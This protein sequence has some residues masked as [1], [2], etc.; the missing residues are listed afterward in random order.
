MFS[1][2]SNWSFETLQQSLQKVKKVFKERHDAVASCQ[3]FLC[4][5]NKVSHCLV[6][7]LIP[8]HVGRG[9]VGCCRNVREAFQVSGFS[10]GTTSFFEAEG[11]D[12]TKLCQKVLQQVG[13]KS[14]FKAEQVQQHIQG[15]CYNQGYNQ[16]RLQ[17]IRYQ[18]RY[19]IATMQGLGSL[20]CTMAK[21]E[22]D[23]TSIYLP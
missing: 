4:Q 16:K 17:L 9:S 22:R 6:S 23:T 20:E 14:Y 8:R 5:Y 7:L 21:S 18:R 3:G 2:I 19:R 13:Q 11:V 12:S 15:I 1:L 10:R